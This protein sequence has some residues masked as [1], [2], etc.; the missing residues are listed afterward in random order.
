MTTVTVLT[1]ATVTFEALVRQVT[2]A[3]F[4]AALGALGVRRLRVQYGHEPNVSAALF[5]ECAAAWRAAGGTECHATAVAV[6]EA[7]GVTVEAFA[8][9]HCLD[10]FIALLDVVVSHAGTGSIVDVLRQHRP[11]VVVVN[12][13]LMDNHQAEVARHM[14]RA[15]HCVVST[16]AGVA[17][18]VAAV[19]ARRVVLQPLPAAAPVVQLILYAEAAASIDP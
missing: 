2:L 8:F 11:L 14:A 19:L 5:G 12:E 6:Y 1:G 15:N 3:P 17:D 18:A 16:V 4:V 13:L 7:Q 10:A 9:L